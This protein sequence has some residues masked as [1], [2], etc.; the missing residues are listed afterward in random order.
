MSLNSH[1]TPPEVMPLPPS[2]APS[3]LEVS[4]SEKEGRGRPPMATP[5]C[6][7]QTSSDAI[8]DSLPFLCLY[9][10]SST[11]RGKPDIRTEASLFVSSSTGRGKPDIRTE[12]SH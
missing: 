5:E 3:S 7:K 12:A 11:G 4:C 2:E 1:L 10:S 8:S 6:G 9:V